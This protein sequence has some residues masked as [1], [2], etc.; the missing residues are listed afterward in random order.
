MLSINQKTILRNLKIHIRK[1]AKMAIDLMR[2]EMKDKTHFRS[3]TKNLHKLVFRG[4][5]WFSK[6]K[7]MFFELETEI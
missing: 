5:G 6:I 3:Q 2:T 1:A 4:G 7:V